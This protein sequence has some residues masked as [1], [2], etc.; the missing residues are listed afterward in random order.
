MDKPPDINSGKDNPTIQWQGTFPSTSSTT[1]RD[2]R[3]MDG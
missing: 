2:Y 3:D 1:N